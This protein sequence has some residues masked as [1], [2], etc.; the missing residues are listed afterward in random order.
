M[1]SKESETEVCVTFVDETEFVNKGN[2]FIQEEENWDKSSTSSLSSDASDLW[3]EEFSDT[4]ECEDESPIPALSQKGKKRATVTS[5]KRKKIVEGKKGDRT[6][7]KALSKTEIVALSEKMLEKKAACW[8]FVS[9]KLAQQP[10]IKHYEMHRTLIQYVLGKRSPELHNFVDHI[11]YTYIKL[12][13][14]IAKEVKTDKKANLTMRWVYSLNSFLECEVC[15]SVYAE[16]PSE[17]SS[18]ST[19]RAVTGMVQSLVYD[20]AQNESNRSSEDADMSN[21]VSPEDDVSLYRMSGAALCNMIKLRKDT[22]S[23][24]EGKRKLT[25]ESRR[26]MENELDILLSLKSLDKSNLPVALK[27]LDEENLTFVKDDFLCF[28]RETDMNIRILK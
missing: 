1:A 12:V 7:K 15:R 27:L 10:V 16:L 14:D 6:K 17:F 21:E 9:Q 25:A 11:Y 8:T 3:S 24:K 23:G 18:E 2:W 20:F 19:T 28:V 22:L 5:A 4:S 26:S 13:N